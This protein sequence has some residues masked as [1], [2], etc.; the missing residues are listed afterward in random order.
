MGFPPPPIDPAIA[1]RP[2]LRA[3]SPFSPEA[4]PPSGSLV[5]AAFALVA[6]LLIAAIAGLT[7]AHGDGRLLDLFLL[8]AGLLVAYGAGLRMAPLSAAA[9]VATYVALEGHYQR[10]DGHHTGS[11]IAFSVVFG[12][13]VLAAG[14]LADGFEAWN[15]TGERA[16]V[17]EPEAEPEP[18]QPSEAGEPPEAETLEALLDD[19]IRAHGALSLL[20]VRADRIEE[21]GHER[22]QEAARAVLD[23]VSDVLWAHLRSTDVLQR[24]GL[25]DFW[26]LLPRT[27][28][29]TARTTAERARLAVG[30]TEVPLDDGQRL[31][32]SISVG[33]SSC[34]IDGRTAETLR[35]AAVRALAA[36]AELGGNRTVL[37]SAPPGAP[38]GWGLAPEA[39]PEPDSAA[40]A[41]RALE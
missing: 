17:A 1:Q 6:G 32:C 15:A 36:A 18:G 13:A 37:H 30:N 39:E 5:L 21:L 31:G 9:L 35:D 34:P 7:A 10:L 29:E 19:A 40:A 4:A 22:G 24:H 33:I 3:R 41:G 8:G 16:L 2:A 28:L 11:V 27:S 25:F 14:A 20:L 26:V 23:R 38:R 12:A